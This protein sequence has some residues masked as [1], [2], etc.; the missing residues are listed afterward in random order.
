MSTELQALESNQTWSI[1][2]LPDG[3]HPVG[4]RW[5][6]KIKVN[7]DGSVERYKA[8]LV[9]K[10]YTQQGG[11]D[12]FDT[13]S[14]VAKFVSVKILLS[15]AAVF[16]WTLSQLDATNAFL[17]GDLNEEVYMTIPP[18]Y[19]GREGEIL[20]SNAVFRLHKSLYGLKQASRQWFQ[21]F[22]NT[23]IQIGFTQSLNDHSLFIKVNG[24]SFLAL[25]VYVDDIIIA[26]ND[27]T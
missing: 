9:A 26:S 14:P 19:A 1:V 16:G 22:S 4:C 23:L 18:G 27:Q 21:K 13:F 10:G 7:A 24:K 20:P 12:Y 15:L 6:Y 5:V 11:I 8:R 2:S 3:K 17:H 25:L